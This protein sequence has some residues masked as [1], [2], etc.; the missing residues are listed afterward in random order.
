MWS[1]SVVCL[2][3]VIIITLRAKA[4]SDV[5]VSVCEVHWFRIQS[6][7]CPL[8]AFPLA[9]EALFA[10]KYSQSLPTSHRCRS[11][12]ADLSAARYKHECVHNKNALENRFWAQEFHFSPE[13]VDFL[14]SVHS[15]TRVCVS[16]VLLLVLDERSVI[17]V[18]SAAS[19]IA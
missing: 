13:T 2:S 5:V 16:V 15:W 12:T 10:L 8:A 17:I 3:H 9:G 19:N 11:G 7:I 14:F 1:A 4:Q 6:F 18:A